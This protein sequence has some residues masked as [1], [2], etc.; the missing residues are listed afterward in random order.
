MPRTYIIT[1]D[2]L[3]TNK[4]KKQMK[5]FTLL[6]FALVAV[7]NVAKADV[8][9]TIWEGSTSMGD[10]AKSITLSPVNYADIEAG[11]ILC[12]YATA[13][14]GKSASYYLQKINSDWSWADFVCKATISFTP[15]GTNANAQ[16]EMTSDFVTELTASGINGLVI[17]GQYYTLTKVSIKK[18]TSMIKHTLSADSKSFANWSTSYTIPAKT[19]TVGDFIYMPATRVTPV[20]ENTNLTEKTVYSD[21]ATNSEGTISFNADNAKYGWTINDSWLNRNGDGAT[22][23]VNFSEAISA[24]VSLVVGYEYE[25]NSETKST[26]VSTTVNSGA[27]TVS[28]SIPTNSTK[29]TNIYLQANN[30]VSVKLGTATASYSNYDP[31]S[32]TQIS[33]TNGANWTTIYAVVKASHDVWKKIENTTDAGYITNNEWHVGGYYY[34]ATGLYLYHPVT[35]F[36]IG[37]IG[38]ATFCADVTVSVPDGIEA[39]Y[40]TVSSDKT[41]IELKKISDGVIP[42]NTGVIIK[43]AAGSVV[44]FT[45]TTTENV[46]TSALTGVTTATTMTAGNYVLYN[47]G[48]TAEFRKVT[49]TELAANKAY[50]PAGAVSEARLSI[51]FDDEETTG[52]SAT[53][54]NN[55]KVNNE[56]Y[57]LS[58][59]RVT[60]P[61]KGLYIVN[62]KKVVI[63]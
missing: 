10:W 15:T 42:A 47:N 24:D 30:G 3:L 32:Q 14:S 57:N 63:K 49:A 12:L 1:K 48:G 25:E 58:G 38:L 50:L 40:A 19:V 6:L 52:I 62:G 34:N 9:W 16:F 59:Q 28:T 53:I 39:Y 18:K 7:V 54:M 20:V 55:E 37:S 17:K 33:Y 26:T 44:E 21:N 46:V 4:T 8:E 27:T 56:Y 51:V 45:A 41:K 23:T 36:S 29:V 35:S 11:D 31:Y 60:Q 5:K 13:E 43:G 22:A 2:I 61:T